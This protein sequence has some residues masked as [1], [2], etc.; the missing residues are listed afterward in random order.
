MNEKL[1][2][3]SRAPQCLCFLIRSKKEKGVHIYL[4]LA[5]SGTVL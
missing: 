1:L 2:I 3:P 4:A 5:G